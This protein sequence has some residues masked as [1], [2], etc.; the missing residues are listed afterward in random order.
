[1]ATSVPTQRP[2]TP[3]PALAQQSAAQMF[4]KLTIE[5]LVPQLAELERKLVVE[6][7]DLKGQVSRLEARF[8]EREAASAKRQPRAG[9]VTGGAT[10]VGAQNVAVGGETIKPPT[11]VMFFC[12]RQWAQD[13]EFRAKY[14]TPRIKTMLEEDPKLQGILDRQKRLLAE[15]S[16]VWKEGLT[17]DQKNAVRAEYKL[18]S[19]QQTLENIAPPLETD[20]NGEK[21]DAYEYYEEHQF[22]AAA[23]VF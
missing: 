10:A 1:M 16:R 14:T 21:G 11:N 22:Q 6:L 2:T 4:A 23:P 13:A 7:A 5:G 18:S 19:V 17:D 3:A 20:N 15:G 9:K 12:R 8:S